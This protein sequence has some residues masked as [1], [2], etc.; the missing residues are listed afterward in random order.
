MIYLYKKTHNITG[1]KYLGKTER[2]PHTYKGSGVYWKRHIKKY[3]YDVTTEI[4]FQTNDKEKFKEI[5]LYYSALWNV[6][7]SN[8]WA[9]F[10]PESGTGVDSESAKRENVKRIKNGTHNFLGG[11]IGGNNSRKRIVDGTHPFLDS[12]IQRNNSIKSNTKR[13]DNGTHNFLLKWK[14][15]Y[16]NKEGQN[17]TNY[18]RWH[19]DN[20]KLKTENIIC[21]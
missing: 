9:N 3:G 15:T 16:C 10:M 5:G 2:D 18:I 12:N 19:G 1:L 14:C 17:K 6:T 20:C 7:E 8:E 4:L 11:E 13:I 21:L